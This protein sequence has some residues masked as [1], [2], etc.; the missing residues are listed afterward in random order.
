MG[1]VGLIYPWDGAATPFSTSPTIFFEASDVWSGQYDLCGIVV[2]H[3][4]VD[5]GRVA[6]R[7]EDKSAQIRGVEPRRFELLT[8]ALQR[9]RSTN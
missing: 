5:H 7:P 3:G 1:H 6:P 9:Q 2:D 8:S 4:R